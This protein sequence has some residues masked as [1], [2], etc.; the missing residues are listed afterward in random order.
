MKHSSSLIPPRSYRSWAKTS[1][2]AR[3]APERTHC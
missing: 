3:N 1:S 2:T